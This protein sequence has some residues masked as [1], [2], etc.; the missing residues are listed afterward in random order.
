MGETI[1]SLLE[2]IQHKELVLPE[3]QRE[4]TWSRTQVRRLFESLFKGYPTGS[5][6]VW[7]TDQPPKIKN[8]AYDLENVRRVKVLLDGQQRLTSLYLHAY[9]EVPPYYNPGE[10]DSSY[11]ELYFNVESGSFG[12]YKKLL[13]ENDPL[14]I[15]VADLFANRPSIY[16][17]VESAQTETPEEK[18]KLFEKIENSLVRLEGILQQEYPVQTVPT[19]A[20]I[21]EAIKVFDLIN[22]Q[23]TP[24]SQADIALAYMTA[25][26]PDI[27][28]VFKQKIEQLEDENFSFDLT[29]L[30]RCIVGIISGVGELE[31][32]GTT[33]EEELKQT[34]AKLNT[35]L[36]YLVSFLRSKAFVIGTDDLNTTNVLVPLVVYLACNG[37]FTQDEESQFLYWMYAALFERRYSGSTETYLDRDISALLANPSPDSLIA[38]LKE[39]EGE[40]R[41]TAANLDS[42]SVSHP[43][44]NMTNIVI[45]ANGAVDWANGLPLVGNVGKDFRIQRHHIFPKSVLAEAGWDT[46]ENLLHR[47]RVHEI[48]NRIPLTQDGNME[49]FTQL[50][51]EYLP[52]V[53][54]RFPGVL[55]RS[56]IPENQSLWKVENY[57]EFLAQR[58]KLIADAIN[59][60]MQGLVE[61]ETGADVQINLVELARK[62]ESTRLE[63]KARLMGGS[64]NYRLEDAVTKAIAGMLNAY[65]GIVLVGVADDGSIVGIEQ[66]YQELSKKNR[67]GFKLHLTSYVAGKLGTGI[68]PLLQTKIEKVDGHDVCAI[69]INPSS[70]PVYFKEKN[71]QHFYVR[72]QNSTRPFSMEEA[73]AYIEER[74]S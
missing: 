24:L 23:G 55:G 31:R 11:F 63:F 21:R 65:G 22:S 14:W 15:Q 2:E 49:I 39:D 29:F 5:L 20:N 47:K 33:S 43:L 58:R 19:D 62:E 69:E 71:F 18:E 50:P 1:Q 54:S 41:I 61:K 52:K 67:D 42:R 73:N 38:T 26:W 27:R 72:T 30:T 17:L 60:F 9:N 35:V 34:W 37:W 3:F 57:A 64:A 59:D 74:F 13:M 16:R 66:D 53:E 6:L 40:P 4:F 36:D 44:Y 48:A 10:I 56:L 32:F 51:A 8:D 7:V 68:L 46:G 45:R 28:R 70:R 25:E 12:Y